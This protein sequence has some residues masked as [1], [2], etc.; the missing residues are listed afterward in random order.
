M[1]TVGWDLKL[2]QGYV[3]NSILNVAGKEIQMEAN[4]KCPNGLNR[5][6]VLVTDAYNLRDR[7]I[8]KVFHGSLLPWGGYESIAVRYIVYY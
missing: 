1:N 8:L 6:E 7:G 3:S 2:E 5:D 4:R